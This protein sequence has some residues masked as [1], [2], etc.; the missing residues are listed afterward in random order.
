MNT[1]NPFSAI[2]LGGNGVFRGV[3]LAVPKE[4]VEALLPTGL[5]LGEQSVT[6]AG[7]HPVIASFNDLT[8]A[9][10][11]VPSLMPVL[12]YNE[13]TL[14]IPYSYIARGG[15]NRNSPGPYYY[16]PRLFLDSMLAVIGGVGFWGFRKV[17]ATFQVDDDRFAIRGDGGQALTSLTWKASGAFKPVSSYPN[18]EPIRRMLDQRLISQVPP[19]GGPIFVVSDFDRRWDAATL[20]PLETTIAIDEDF[21][22]DV[23]SFASCTVGRGTT[24]PGIDKSVLGSY[25]LDTPWRLSFPYLPIMREWA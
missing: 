4:R 20:R 3:T 11:S 25:E 6:P 8:H 16:M 12:N 7:T 14:G 22:P 2:N 9:Q 5:A 15:L 21:V 10:M 23:K 17:P 19:L 13:Y 18:F 24:S 1:L